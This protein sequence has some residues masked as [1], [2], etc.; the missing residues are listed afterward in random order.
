MNWTHA[1][2][3]PYSF[4]YAGSKGKMI[5]LEKQKYYETTSTNDGSV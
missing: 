2:S 1:I 5:T 4:K 3:F